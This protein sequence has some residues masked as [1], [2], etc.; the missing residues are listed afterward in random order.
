MRVPYQFNV[1]SLPHDDPDLPSW[2]GRFLER[3]SLLLH[4][5]A[6]SLPGPTE[7]P[8]GNV[9]AAAT[10]KFKLADVVTAR[11]TAN[12]TLTLDTETRTG[13]EGLLELTQDGG[14]AD[15]RSLWANVT[16]GRWARRRRS[17]PARGSARC[18]GFTFRGGA[19]VGRVVASNY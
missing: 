14:S 17:P 5:I 11:L 4:R 12:T 1:P 13:A 8:L 6:Q 2:F 7:R 16:L 9:G 15:A 19:W 18:I 10:V 3:H